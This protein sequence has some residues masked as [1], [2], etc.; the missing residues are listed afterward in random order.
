MHVMNDRVW[1]VITAGAPRRRQS[2]LPQTHTA[3]YKHRQRMEQKKETAGQYKA[4]VSC[5]FCSSWLKCTNFVITYV[6]LGL[7]SV[8]DS[9]EKLFKVRQVLIFNLC[10]INLKM[11]IEAILYTIQHY[12]STT[13]RLQEQMIFRF[14]YFLFSST[15][16]LCFSTY[17]LCDFYTV[18]LIFIFI[19][20]II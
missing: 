16:T 13:S 12:K 14:L 1:W 9:Q 11:L 15:Y 6:F 5:R 19:Y 20:S 4:Q 8:G 10:S 18:L 17:R 2:Q 3:I 7:S